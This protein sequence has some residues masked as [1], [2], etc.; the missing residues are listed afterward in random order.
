MPEHR[1]DR[2]E[3]WEAGAS[4]AREARGGGR[5]GRAQQRDPG[6]RQALPLGPTSRRRRFD[7]RGRQ[8]PSPEL[9]DGRLA[10]PGL[11]HQCKRADTGWSVAA[12]A[13]SPADEFRRLR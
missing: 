4:G 9:F 1:L 11:Q 5:A 12:P 7:K 3:E 6:E 8:R 10:A 13:P 2:G